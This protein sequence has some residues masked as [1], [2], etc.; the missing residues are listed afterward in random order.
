MN[1]PNPNPFFFVCSPLAVLLV[2]GSFLTDS[3]GVA[4]LEGVAS[5]VA[6]L[7]ISEVAFEV[8]S[9]LKIL[10]SW[11]QCLKNIITNNFFQEQK[12]YILYI[13]KK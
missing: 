6:A 8:A 1:L 13:A 11:L 7:E 4:P 5:L 9:V 3:V 10:Y 2:L 12:I